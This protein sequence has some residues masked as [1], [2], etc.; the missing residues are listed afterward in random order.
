MEEVEQGLDIADIHTEIIII[1][2]KFKYYI[3]YFII[4]NYGNKS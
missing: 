2:S 3:F 1:E 4:D